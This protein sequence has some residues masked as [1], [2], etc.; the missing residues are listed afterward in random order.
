MATQT[1]LP[2]AN[3]RTQV[4]SQH[5]FLRR[6]LLTN[7]LFSAIS[8]SVVAALAN[9]IAEFMGLSSAV[10]LM[11][12]ALALLPFAFGVYRVAT[13]EVLQKSFVRIIF[14]MD[15]A[16]VV[17]SLVLLATNALALTTAG[18]WAVLIVADA[19]MLFAIGEYIGL[20][21]LR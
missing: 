12:V 20:R 9:P 19:V 13:Q 8:G 21:R 16:W 4:N 5:Q 1:V 2:A 7:S 15:V 14:F 17:A 10:P 18:N 11:L 6:V 3:E